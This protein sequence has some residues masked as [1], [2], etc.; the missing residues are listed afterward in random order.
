MADGQESG[1]ADISSL[2]ELAGVLI[3]GGFLALLAIAAASL[4]GV[5]T[6]ETGLAYFTSFVAAGGI[7]VLIFLGAF[8]AGSLLGF[9]FG[10]PRTAAEPAPDTSSTALAAQAVVPS[11]SAAGSTPTTTTLRTKK[12]L[13]QSNTNLEKISDWLTT[14][15]VGAG[16]VQLH[17]VD[18]ALYRFRLF[19]ET[20]AAVFRF[21]NGEANA[22]LIPVI[23]PV[24][25]IF[26]LAGG[27]LYMYLSTRLVLIRLFQ[28]VEDI[29][30]G[31]HLDLLPAEA[32]AQVTRQTGATGPGNF[33]ARNI[34]AKAK[35][36]TRDALEVMFDLL[37]KDVPDDVI[38][39]GASLSQTSAVN[40]PDYW[41][42][43]AAA[44]GQKFNKAETDSDKESARDN[45]L[46]CVRRSVALD[47]DY[48]E[49]LWSLSD[50][51]AF[52]DDLSGLRDDR[53]FLRLVG[54]LPAESVSGV[55]ARAKRRP[56]T[57]K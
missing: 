32:R 38:G 18:D 39:L 19:L 51:N 54:R 34:G 41:Y 28:Q 24:M 46:D 35:P 5:G 27:F 48:R 30:E 26:G 45:A 31:K 13:L 3:L 50:P 36:T 17:A 56:P 37:Y 53:E 2:G 49:L 33:I 29:L 4:S 20:S 43:L 22:G 16:L 55:P 12:R 11:P 7:C 21:D 14:L 57:R 23:G 6:A 15:L 25:L 52:E 1:R 44:F 40:D 8:A 47:S 42:Y 10:V 9:I